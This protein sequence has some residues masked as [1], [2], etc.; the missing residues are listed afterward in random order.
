MSEIYFANEFESGKGIEEVG[1]DID[2]IRSWIDHY[3]GG[4]WGHMGDCYNILY[5]YVYVWRFL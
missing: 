2:E 5:T 4:M 1:I 3:W